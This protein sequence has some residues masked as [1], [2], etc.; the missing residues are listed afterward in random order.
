MGTYG[1]LDDDVVGSHSLGRGGLLHGHG[2]GVPSGLLL[3]FVGRLEP[4]EHDEM[5]RMCEE[6]VEGG[7]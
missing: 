7:V 3:G 1:L 4:A 5:I 6:K 2:S